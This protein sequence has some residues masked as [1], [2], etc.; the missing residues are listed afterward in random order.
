MATTLPV[1]D[2]D[3]ATIFPVILAPDAVK[4][5]VLVTLNGAADAVALPA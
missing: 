2:P 1:K 3:V 4:Y 5:P